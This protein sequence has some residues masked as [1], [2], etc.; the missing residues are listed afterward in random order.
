MTTAKAITCQTVGNMVYVRDERGNLLDTLGF[1]QPVM[2]QSFGTGFS[3]VCGTMCYTYML[4]NGQ[5]RRTGT[6]G[7]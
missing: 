1:P 5:I 4:E 7:V 3:V 6:H 2:V